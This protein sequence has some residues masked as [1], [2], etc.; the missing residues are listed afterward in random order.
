MSTTTTSLPTTTNGNGHTAARKTP[1]RKAGVRATTAKPTAP[2]A[3]PIAAAVMPMAG[4]IAKPP[5]LSIAALRDRESQLET[6]NRISA[7]RLAEIRSLIASAAR[8][9]PAPRKL[10]RAKGRR[11][12]KAA[13]AQRAA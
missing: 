5:A 9:N 6:E 1:G 2:T 10:T 13:P 11:G 4:T 12:R 8:S 7:G 3:A